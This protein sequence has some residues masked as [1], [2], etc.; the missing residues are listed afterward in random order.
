MRMAVSW[1]CLTRFQIFDFINKANDPSQNP[2][3]AG[4]FYW[5]EIIGTVYIVCTFASGV[6]Y[7]KTRYRK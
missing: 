4:F 5:G 7:D 1:V 2:V 6:L 3:Y